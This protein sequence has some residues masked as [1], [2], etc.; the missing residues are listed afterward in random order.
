MPSEI[1]AVDLNSRTPSDKF[2][3]LLTLRTTS[4]ASQVIADAE[5]RRIAHSELKR[6]ARM[7]PQGW[8]PPAISNTTPITTIINLLKRHFRYHIINKEFFKEKHDTENWPSINF[9]VPVPGNYLDQ[10]IDKIRKGNFPNL[11]RLNCSSVEINI[12]NM[13]ELA[14]L[15]NDD[16]FPRLEELEM[17]GFGLS[18][19]QE[20]TKNIDALIAFLRSVEIGK[21]DK[22]KKFSLCNNMEH[23]DDEQRELALDTLLRKVNNGL[24]AGCEY[25][26]LTDN[27]IDNI[28]S[29]PFISAISFGKLPNIQ[30]LLFDHPKHRDADQA[31]I[32]RID[33]A[34]ENKKNRKRQMPPS[35]HKGKSG[36]L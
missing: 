7:V 15:F 3:Q 2:Y 19:A 31:R 16:L 1:S 6:M 18:R 23:I 17:T 30:K 27:G 26:D 12:K 29:F 13:T 20:T 9:E 11:V 5:I 4:K 35:Y 36:K 28:E 33:E 22:I 34:I 14:G 21:M 8:T 25:L 32:R 10:V 24:L